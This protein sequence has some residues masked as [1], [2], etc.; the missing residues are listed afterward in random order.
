MAI[1]HIE[2]GRLISLYSGV[3]DFSLPPTLTPR[4]PPALAVQHVEPVVC[5]ADDPWPQQ[6]EAGALTVPTSPLRP[7][8]RAK[9]LAWKYQVQQLGLSHC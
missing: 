9:V 3:H 6:S 4:I 8:V 7:T 2:A 1:A 5:C